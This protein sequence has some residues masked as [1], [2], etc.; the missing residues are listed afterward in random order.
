VLVLRRKDLNRSNL[1]AGTFVIALSMLF[2]SAANAQSANGI[3]AGAVT[4]STGAAISGATVTVTSL[5]TNAVRTVMTGRSGN[6]RLEAE[7]PGPYRVDITAKSFS[8]TSVARADVSASVITSVNVV[9]I[10]GSTTDTVEVTGDVAALKT[11]SG[12]LSETL[13]TKEINTLPISSLNPYALATTLPGVTTVT[14]ASYTNGASYSVNG[15]RPRDN[16]FLIEGV[17]NNDQGIHGQAFQPENLEAISEA[18]FLLDSFS[19]EYGRGG[20]VSNVTLKSG[21][22]A[23]H[24]AVYERFENSSLDATDKHD[25]LFGNPKSKTRENIFGFRVGG[26]VI[27]DRWFFF[28][29]NLWDRFRATSNLSELTLPTSG[30]YT[31]LNQ[32][33]SNARIANLIKAY[34]GLVGTNNSFAVSE[35]L[36]LDPVTNVN[37]GVVNF[38]GVQRSLGNLSNSRELEATS[39]VLLND[40]DKLRFRFIQSPNSVPYDTVNFPSQLPGFDTDQQGVVYNA[41]ITETHIFSPN[42]LNELRLSW[43]RIGFNFDL[44]PETY[45]NPLALSPAIGISGITGYGIPAGSV[46]QGRFQDTYQLQDAVSITKGRNSLKFGIDLA[47]LRIKDGIPFNFYGSINYEEQVGGGYSALADYLDD[48]SGAGSSSPESANIDF[49]NP[50]AR[51]NIWTQNYYIQDSYQLFPNLEIDAGLR[52]EYNGTPFNYLGYPAIDLNNPAAFPQTTKQVGD[53]NNF[54]PRLGFNYSPTKGG[55]TVISGG[56]GVFYSHVFTNIIDNIQGSSPNAAAKDVLALTSGRGSP[57]WSQAL[58]VCATCLITTKTPLAMDTANVI[59]SHLLDPLTY[60][61]NLR[62]QHEL[63]G[64]VVAAISYVGNRSEHEYTTDEYNP[65][66]PSGARLIPTRGRIILE[67]NQGDSN[68]NA[69][70]LELAKKERHGISFR[71]VYTY[72]KNLDDGSEIF[73]DSDSNGSTYAEIQRA[74]RAR[75]Y[76]ASLFDHRHRFVF[77][78]VWQAPLWHPEGGMRVAAAI[79]NGFTFAGI[80]SFQS[81]QPVNVEIGYDWNGDGISNDRPILLT[82]SAPITN[83]AVKGEDFFNVPVGTLCDGPRFWATNDPCQIVQASN[84]H[85]VTSNFGTTQNTVARNYLFTDHVVDT[86]LT[87]ERS[88]KVIGEHSFSIR[89]EAI[90]A[91]N[92]GNTGSSGG[93]FNATLITGVP[94]NGTDSLGNVYTGQTTFDNRYLTTAGGRV[95]RFYARYQF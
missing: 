69:G 62:V 72:S 80:T 5:E 20:S 73:T 26:P 56:F 8:K 55:K 32:Y 38:A 91:L 90:N 33:A 59:A 23:F 66:E 71:A 88:F 89:A 87:V 41:G 93:N 17:D 1:Y 86:D 34:G 2:G 51:P 75:E 24:G 19:A 4:D 63:P 53:K 42:I 47:N 15:N 6:Y 43:D 49:G 28:V 81:G 74:P 70:Q 48:Y 94:F 78:G 46:P 52:Y 36:G 85:W 31:T 12:E 67:D 58:N 18:T 13:S 40:R 79:V 95:L 22:N 14:A 84:T 82:K 45:A 68:Y 44:R 10:A 64:A 50:T 57:N 21:T 27:K 77:S 54:G 92:Q 7:Q 65:F 16:N 30:G 83:W 25:V 9:L 3:I 11:E 29:S 37:R 60:E 61:Y 39:D 76:A 35:N